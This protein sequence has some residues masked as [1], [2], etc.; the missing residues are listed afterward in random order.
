[1]WIVTKIGFFSLTNH[2]DQ[3]TNMMVRGRVR[4][5]MER[6][7]NLLP[8]SAMSSGIIETDDSDYRYRVIADRDAVGELVGRLAANMDYIG[9]KDTIAEVSGH[10]RADIYFN[11]WEDL[12]ALAS[13]EGYILAEE[14]IPK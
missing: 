6:L 2:R 10:T 12:H 9:F 11:L 14:T 1:M 13:Y 4:T 8:K 5:D 7:V 3:P